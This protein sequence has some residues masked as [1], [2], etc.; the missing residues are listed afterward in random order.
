MIIMPLASFNNVLSNLQIFFKDIE[1][2]IANFWKV[3][4]PIVQILLTAVLIVSSLNIIISLVKAIIQNHKE[5]KPIPN[6]N[7][8]YSFIA[9]TATYQRHLIYKDAHKLLFDKKW[10]YVSFAGLAYRLG[11]YVNNSKSIRFICS[12]VYAPLAI[13]GLFEMVFRA[14]IGVLFYFV[15]NI[16]YALLLLALWIINGIILLIFRIIDRSTWVTQHCPN[17]Y[18]TFKLPL[19]KCPY[20]GELHENLYP[21]VKG[22]FFAKCSCGHFIP[23]SV[24]SR[25]KHLSSYCPKCK[26]ELAASNVKALSIQIVGGNSSGKTA[27]ISAFQHMYL[28]SLQSSGNNNIITSPEDKFNELEMMFLNGMTKQ[29]P[30]DEAQAY[31]FLHKKK[32]TM[33]DGLVLYDIPDEI[34]LSEQYERNPL[35]FGYSDGIVILIDPLSVNSVRNECEKSNGTN[36]INGFSDDNAES[37]IVHFINKYSEVAGRLAKHMSDVPV[38]VLIS[39]SDL[40]I[41]KRRIGYIKTKAEYE[42]NP[43]QYLNMDDAR[44]QLCRKYLAEIG[45]S[46]VLNNLDSV[47]SNVAYFPIS[48]IGHVHQMGIPFEPQGVIEPITWIAKECKNSLYYTIKNVEEMSK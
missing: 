29:S 40:T 32:G 20:C 39:K 38:A 45:L 15:L 24:V 19:F 41:V 17:D 34:I 46:N 21:G 28:Y 37:I 43:T 35:N 48:A 26:Y 22:V 33:D 42:K 44:N 8:M 23:C 30:T 16:L 6:T 2:G 1:K 18:A 11:N 25:R 13:L 3:L 7:L 10:S 12:M 4:P 36:S 14:V 27:Y 31:Y 9:G 5:W 47:F